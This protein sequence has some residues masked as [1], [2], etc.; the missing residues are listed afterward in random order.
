LRFPGGQRGVVAAAA[1]TPL[2]KRRHHEHRPACPRHA[3]VLT[4]RDFSE[5]T[6]ALTRN[7]FDGPT[8]YYLNHDV[9]ARYAD[10]APGGRVLW[11]GGGRDPG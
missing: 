5:L 7:G 10:A 3:T 1:A 9:N 4:E 2:A 11:R 8:G 6:S